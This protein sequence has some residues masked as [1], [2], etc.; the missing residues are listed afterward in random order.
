M[1]SLWSKYEKGTIGNL[2]AILRK[3]R[4]LIALFGLGIKVLID[5]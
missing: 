5:T 2:K 4:K 1:N 3:T